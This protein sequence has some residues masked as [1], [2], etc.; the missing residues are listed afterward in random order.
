MR[1]QH[2]YRLPDPAN[3]LDPEIASAMVAHEPLVIPEKFDGYIPKDDLTDFQGRDLKLI[4]AL[5]EQAQWL[6]CL[7]DIVERQD[8]IIRQLNANQARMK[9]EISKEKSQQ[10]EFKTVWRILRWAVLL[11]AGG[12]LTALGQWF[13]K[14]P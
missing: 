10:Q 3:P 5:S 6:D 1:R 12:A 9:I 7:I 11:I 13:V 2:Q 4:L 8:K 14:R